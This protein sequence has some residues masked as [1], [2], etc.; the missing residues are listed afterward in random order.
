M[1]TSGAPGDQPMTASPLNVVVAGGG[2]AGLE[3][4]LGLHELAG[5]RVQLTLVAPDADFSYRPLAVAEPFAAGRAQRVPLTRFAEATGAALVRDA[6]AGV[7]DRARALRL[8]D[9]RTQRFDALLVA[10]G[11]VPVAAVDSATTWWPGGDPE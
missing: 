5:D 11:G 7:D 2:I 8:R 3:A 4:M 1:P 10:P 6:L 9:G